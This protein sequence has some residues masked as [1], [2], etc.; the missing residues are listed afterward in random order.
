MYRLLEYFFATDA[1]YWCLG[2]L[3][4]GSLVTCWLFPE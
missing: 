3:A 2:G 1:W 4:V